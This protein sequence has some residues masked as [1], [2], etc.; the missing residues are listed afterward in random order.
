[1]LTTNS[2]TQEKTLFLIFISRDY[3]CDVNVGAPRLLWRVQITCPITNK[4]LFSPS[5]G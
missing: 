1:M 3:D 5:S 2:Y 4:I